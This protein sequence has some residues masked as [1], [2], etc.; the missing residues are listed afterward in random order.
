MQQTQTDHQIF[1]GDAQGGGRTSSLSPVLIG[2]M[3]PMLL[4]L[5]VAPTILQGAAG[6]IGALLV[7]VLVLSLG[8][9]VLS[10]LA[11]GEPVGFS[12]DTQARS[13]SILREGIVARSRIEVPFS[14]IGRLK[15]V[16]RFDRDGYECS[17]VE[18]LTGNGDS[19]IVSANSLD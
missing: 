13:A 8:A 2:V 3:A 15:S 16:A 1:V 12:F 17:A 18:L 7:F 4:G 11:P 19:W 5:L 9:Y 10:V 6:V 14:E